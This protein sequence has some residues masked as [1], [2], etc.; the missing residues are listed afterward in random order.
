[1][2]SHVDR[3]RPTCDTVGSPAVTGHLVTG[4]LVTGHLVTGHLVAAQA[5]SHGEMGAKV[6]GT[7]I[8]RA[9]STTR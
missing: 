5:W 6:G 7:G 9:H 8:A 2:I 4:H 1:V 3:L